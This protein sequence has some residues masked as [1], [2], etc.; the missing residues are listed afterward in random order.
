MTHVR[1]CCALALRLD[2]TEFGITALQNSGYKILFQ[3][4]LSR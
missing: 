3:N 2:D 1:D 4:D